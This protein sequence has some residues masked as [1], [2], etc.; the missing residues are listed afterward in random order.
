MPRSRALRYA[1]FVNRVYSPRAKTLIRL[2]TANLLTIPW[3]PALAVANSVPQTYKTAIHYLT[4]VSFTLSLL[5]PLLS[6]T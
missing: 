5:Y 1:G 4:N 2:S 6:H 3:A